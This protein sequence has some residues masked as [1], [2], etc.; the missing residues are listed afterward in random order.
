MTTTK[1]G[2]HVVNH[3]SNFMRYISAKLSHRADVTMKHE[4]VDV[5]IVTKLKLYFVDWIRNRGGGEL[6]R[7]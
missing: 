3:F 4:I 2:R 7:N 6:S 1:N 5:E